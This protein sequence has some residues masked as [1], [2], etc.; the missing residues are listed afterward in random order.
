MGQRDRLGPLRRLLLAAVLLAQQAGALDVSG[1]GSSSL[2]I[3]DWSAAGATIQDI[4]RAVGCDRDTPSHMPEVWAP[5]RADLDLQSLLA[6]FASTLRMPHAKF[7]GAGG[8]PLDAQARPESVD[9]VVAMI[10][11]ESEPRSVVLHLEALETVPPPF[12]EML[13][14]FLPLTNLTAHVYISNHTRLSI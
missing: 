9:D 12:A 7:A 8:A 2:S 10:A 13:R 1:D 6:P 3:A 14:P 5:P 4:V 11:Q